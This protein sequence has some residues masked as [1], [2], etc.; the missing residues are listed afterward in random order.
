[1][2]K[3][4]SREPQPYQNE[5]WLREKYWD[6]RLSSGEIAKLCDTTPSTIARWLRKLEI[7]R[8]D[9]HEHALPDDQRYRDEDWLREHL[10]NRGR[11][12]RSVA[13]SCGVA[14]STIREWA[15]R[16]GINRRE[17][18][19]A[20]D[21][22]QDADWLREQYTGRRKSTTEI[23]DEVG[24]TS[25]TV[26]KW[27]DRHDIEL[28]STSEA[29]RLTQLTNLPS[30][31]INEYGYVRWRS[32]H[33]GDRFDIAVHRLLAVSEFGF[34]AVCGKVVHHE[35]HIPWDNRP[36]NLR[37]MDLEKH[38]EYHSRDHIDGGPWRDEE[39]LREARQEHTRT[40]LAERWGTSY[41][42]IQRWEKKFDIDGV[43]DPHYDGPWRDEE[44]L[45]NA[46][47]SATISELA[48]RWGCSETTVTNWLSRFDI[49][50]DDV[51]RSSQ[52]PLSE[53]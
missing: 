41:S 17:A 19:E 32:M 22:L 3:K 37:L 12:A 31:Q 5:D 50:K 10:E 33:D 29:A 48:E 28:R 13:D 38:T 46:Y 20:P 21:E 47:S 36:G 43:D 23:A 39:K 51:E 44:T 9:P 4:G 1:M 14:A 7:E 26:S 11:S 24:C 18:D 40:E 16:Y 2:V 34:D 6:E 8:R 35:S 52:K 49:S 53:F 45:R 42:T 15:D 30:L 27:L 25:T